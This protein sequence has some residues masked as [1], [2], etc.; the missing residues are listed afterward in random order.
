MM[1]LRQCG[2]KL[3]DIAI[4][5]LHEDMVID[6]LFSGELQGQVDELSGTYQDPG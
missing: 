5:L 1:V 4:F 3:C 2:R 6:I